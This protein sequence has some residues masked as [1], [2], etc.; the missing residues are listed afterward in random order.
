MKKI[1][2]IFLCL[3]FFAVNTFPLGVDIN[4]IKVKKSIVFIN[5]KG[6]LPNVPVAKILGIGEN[7]S[8]SLSKNKTMG[9]SGSGYIIYH[10]VDPAEKEKFDA[11]VLNLTRYS[12][13]KHVDTLRLIIAGFLQ[14]QYGY[15]FKDARTLAVF[16]T[17][18]N[19]VYRQNVAYFGTKYKQVAMKYI[20]EKNA[21]LAVNYKE[22]PGATMMLIPLSEDAKKSDLS[23]LD[24]SEISTTDVTDKMNR[25]DEKTIQDRKD[26]V[27]LKEKE[28]TQDK[29]EVAKDKDKLAQ[30]KQKLEDE[31]KKLEEEKKKTEAITDKTERD[32][33]TEELK[34]E[35]EKIAQK[36]DTIKKEEQA[37][38]NKEEKI[39]KK[40]EEIQKDK[41]NIQKDEA[42]N[43]IKKDPDKYA[44][45]L[46]KKEEDLKKQE[47]VL[48]NQ[49]TDK[50][51]YAGKFYYLKVLEYLAAGH[52]NNEMY[53]INANTGEVLVEPPFS[54]ISGR[55]FDVSSAGVVVIT[56]KGSE[57]PNSYLSLLDLDTL[58]I[59]KTSE[60]EIF[61]RSFVEIKEKEIF[62]V[63]HIGTNYRLGKYDLDLKRLAISEEYIDPETFVS[64][65]G[66]RLYV[67]SADK[68]IL[69]LSK[70]D[71]SLIGKIN[72]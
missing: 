18:Y 72:P 43:E 33:K 64:F 8:D 1:T 49:E 28:V 16:L 4:E 44:E 14:K 63:A 54:N 24:T 58:E 39:A 38:T 23:S 20:N 22:W 27:D 9:K 57:V 61:H 34:K 67:N 51:I 25:E 41:E 68:Q 53:I 55:K 46:L 36:E 62:A 7:L 31:K 47:E 52:Y 40:E 37:I 12:A 59:K 42:V 50:N 48:K 71:L 13:V 19:A 70:K 5:Y 65:Y 2:F 15:T 11:D 60:D 66:D 17:Y 69:V 6:K 35:E 30:D 32:K 3:V 45:E 21:G 26:L 29:E 56:H 10:A